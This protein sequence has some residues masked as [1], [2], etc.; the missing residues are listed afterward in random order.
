MLRAP[1]LP[2]LYASGRGAKRDFWP[3]LTA[4]LEAGL[5]DGPANFGGGL[6]TCDETAESEVSAEEAQAFLAS[7]AVP[8]EAT[9]FAAAEADDDDDEYG[10]L[11]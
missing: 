1:R 11:N 5:S 10:D 6:I 4:S 8:G 2:R 7:T 3:T 9:P